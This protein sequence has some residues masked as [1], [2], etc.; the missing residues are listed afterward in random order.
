MFFFDHLLAVYTA[1]LTSEN[2][3][4]M[5]YS[6]VNDI[7]SSS[8]PLMDKLWTI[9]QSKKTVKCKKTEIEH[10]LLNWKWWI[11]YTVDFTTQ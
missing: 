11:I 4:I 7:G 5:Y 10:P 9:N 6:Y 2:I 8:V 1:I 3:T